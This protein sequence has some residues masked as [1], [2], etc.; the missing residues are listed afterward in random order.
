MTKLFAIALMLFGCATLALGLVQEKLRQARIKNAAKERLIDDLQGQLVDKVRDKIEL[1][2]RSS[3]QRR[4][5]DELI[6]DYIYRQDVVKEMGEELKSIHKE[7]YVLLQA[8]YPQLTDLDLLVLCL[9]S[10]SMSNEEI[11][12]VVHMEKRTLYRRRQLISQ[13]IGIYS[14]GLEDFACQIFG[15]EKEEETIQP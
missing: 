8:K 4:Q 6:A 2:Q 5:K 14:T 10:M 9:L 7:E 12:E 11:C 13:R 1:T 3:M 15:T